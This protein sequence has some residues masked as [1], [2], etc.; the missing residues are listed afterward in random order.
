MTR[1]HILRMSHHL[2][3][4]FQKHNINK[5][6]N[7]CEDEVNIKE[8]RQKRETQVLPWSDIQVFWSSFPSA[9]YHLH[10]KFLKND[11]E[12]W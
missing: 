1:Q 6:K 11:R 4:K 9:V 3:K 12:A 2:F 10:L 8:K 5:K 7:K